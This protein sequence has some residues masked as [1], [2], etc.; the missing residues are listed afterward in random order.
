MSTSSVG[1][2]NPHCRVNVCAVIVLGQPG[3]R[4][5]LFWTPH[6]LFSLESSI[7]VGHGYKSFS[8]LFVPCLGSSNRIITAIEHV[9][10]EIT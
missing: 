1:F 7:L 3:L 6:E 10:C 2:V 5:D 8:F 4:H 9:N